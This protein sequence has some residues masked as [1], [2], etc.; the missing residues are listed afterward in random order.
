MKFFSCPIIMVGLFVYLFICI[1]CVRLNVNG[2]SFLFF[3]LSSKSIVKGVSVTQLDS[4][5]VCLLYR[6]FKINE[7]IYIL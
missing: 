6:Q 5:T 7:F 2:L 1:V 3:F 4:W